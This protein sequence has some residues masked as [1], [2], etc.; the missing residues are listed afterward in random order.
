MVGHAVQECYGIVGMSSPTPSEGLAS[1]FTANKLRRGIQLTST[2]KG[3]NVQLYVVM[4]Y[5]TNISAVSQNLVDRVA[6]VLKEI[7]KV[8]VDAI[9]VHVTDIKVRK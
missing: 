8:P 3:I 9:E 6:F 1:A 4:E 5:G 7:A 2:E